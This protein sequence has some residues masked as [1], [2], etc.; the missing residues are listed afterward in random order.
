MQFNSESNGLDLYTDARFWLGI[1]TGDGGGTA[2][3][4]TYPIKMFTRNANMGLD[5]CNALALKGDGIWQFDDSNQSGELLD[6]STNL[7][8]GTQK[9]ALS[10]TWLRIARI[11]IKD[12]A[13]NWITLVKRDRR[14]ASD[15]QIAA[16]GTPYAYDI[17]GGYIYLY[18]IPNYSSTGG[19]EVQFQRGPSYFAYTDTTKVPGF[20]VTFHRLIS[21]MAALDYAEANDMNAR[22]ATLREKIGVAPDVSNGIAGSGMLK[23]FC[24]HYAQRDE[25]GVPNIG[26]RQEDYGQGSLGGSGLPF[27]SNDNPKGW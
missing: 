26:M 22:A 19:M 1:E 24:D 20:V 15:A 27:S 18:N 3:T 11:R 10:V 7:A 16:S 6:V 14:Q 2:D 9:Y 8:S 25:D 21:M 4:T 17:M 5:I 12:S 13:G 23:Q